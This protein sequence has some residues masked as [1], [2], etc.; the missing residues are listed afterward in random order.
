VFQRYEVN[1]D[2]GKMTIRAGD[3]LGPD[4]VLETVR[5]ERLQVLTQTRISRLLEIRDG[6]KVI[7]NPEPDR[8]VPKDKAEID[9]ARQ[10]YL[11][12]F[13]RRLP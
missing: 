7:S 8:E 11:E 5:A 3:D 10:A 13:L 6:T 4:Y 1:P 12:R 2:T 9:K